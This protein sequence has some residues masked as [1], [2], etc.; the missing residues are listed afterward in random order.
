MK[1]HFGFTRRHLLAGIAGLT[2]GGLLPRG[3][4][5]DPA[6]AGRGLTLADIGVGDPGDWSRFEKPTGNSVNVVSMGNAPRRWS[7]SCSPAAG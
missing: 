7:I 2:A 4:L 1:S 3:G 6:L 5:I